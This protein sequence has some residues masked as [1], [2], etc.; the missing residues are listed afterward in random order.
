MSKYRQEQTSDSLELLLDTMCN[1]FGGIMFIAI[2]LLIISSFVSQSPTVENIESVTIQEMQITLLKL[3]TKSDKLNTK[4]S[5]KKIIIDNMKM[6]ENSGIIQNIA[7]L[8]KENILLSDEMQSEKEKLNKVRKEN[9]KLKQSI[10][11]HENSIS[12]SDREKA[13]LEYEL[14]KIKSQYENI[15][16]DATPQENRK[17]SF[18]HLK[19]TSCL[20]SWGILSKNKLY[21]IDRDTTCTQLIDGGS[22]YMPKPNSGVVIGKTITRDVERFCTSLYLNKRFLSLFVMPDSFESMITLKKYV[23]KNN[24]T[25]NWYPITDINEC[26]LRPITADDIFQ[27]E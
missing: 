25:C 17:L 2:S 27:S 19:T 21:I 9:L 11:E 12:K 15:S 7:K 23:R 22:R 26:L 16:K 3:Q 6:I 14:S 24:F 18:T 5:K 10:E 4:I 13:E 20:P 1:T 8:K